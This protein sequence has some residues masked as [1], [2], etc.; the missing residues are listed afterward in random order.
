MSDAAAKFDREF[1]KC[2][3]ALANRAEVDHLLYI[4]DVPIEPSDLRGRKCRKKL[5]YAVTNDGIAEEFRAKKETALVIPAY[6]YSRT[7]RVKVAMVSALQ[8]GAF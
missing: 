6:D 8:Q 7:E 1:L 5:V 2:A 3:L 4:G